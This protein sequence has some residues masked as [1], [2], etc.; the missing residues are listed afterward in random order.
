MK[1]SE[2]NFNIVI[3]ALLKSYPEYKLYPDVSELENIHNNNIYNLQD[4]KQTF[5]LLQ[6]SLK[7]SNEDIK[8]VI[9]KKNIELEKLKND[10]KK[11]TARYNILKDSDQS[12]VG[13]RS[14]FDD[15]YKQNYLSLFLLMSFTL[16]IGFTGTKKIYE[17]RQSIINK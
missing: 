16:I 9:N 17:L 4:V 1:D 7:N 8:R 15:T 10:N 5:L 6:N 2:T 3:N 14:Q 11:L 12:S 13:L